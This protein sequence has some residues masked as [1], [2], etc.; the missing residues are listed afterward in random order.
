MAVVPQGKPTTAYKPNSR[1]TNPAVSSFATS[2]R[3]GLTTAR[4]IFDA[5]ILWLED[6]DSFILEDG[7]DLELD[8]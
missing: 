2:I 6:G 3:P 7:S 8:L 1:E 4:L 5:Y